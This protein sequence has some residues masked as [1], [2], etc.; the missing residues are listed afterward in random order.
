MSKNISECD[1][2]LSNTA[3]SLTLDPHL[4]HQLS[5]KTRSEKYV[6]LLDKEYNKVFEESTR[7]LVDVQNENLRESGNKLQ[8]SANGKNASG[9][10]IMLRDSE[11]SFTT[12][13]SFSL[14]GERYNSFRKTTS[15][16]GSHLSNVFTSSEGIENIGFSCIDQTNSDNTDFRTHE[17][18]CWEQKHLTNSPLTYQASEQNINLPNESDHDSPKSSFKFFSSPKFMKKLT[19][20]K[21][22][23][24]IF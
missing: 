8:F 6:S 24:K 4:S 11:S 23:K 10:D 1:A 9:S 3:T 21:L 14:S 13:S 20:P 22:D 19:S 18:K 16:S 2:E 15:S 5:N 7:S 17:S 12:E